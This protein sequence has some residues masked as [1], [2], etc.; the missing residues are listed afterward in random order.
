MYSDNSQTTHSNPTTL[1]R[2]HGRLLQD[3]G[4]SR[5]QR[6]EVF[7]VISN[8]VIENSQ[9]L[10]KMRS[11]G[12]CY[13]DTSS[14]TQSDTQSSSGSH[15]AEFIALVKRTKV[16]EVQP[17]VDFVQL[18]NTESEEEVNE[19]PKPTL[20]PLPE[21][22]TTEES[23]TYHSQSPAERERTEME[24]K[25]CTGGK[26][27]NRRF[28]RHKVK[29]LLSEYYETSQSYVTKKWMLPPGDTKTK[30]VHHAPV[31]YDR[32][33]KFG[34]VKK[35]GEIK[36]SHSKSK[37]N[38]AKD[39]KTCLNDKMINFALGESYVKNEIRA[40]HP[41]YFK[42][43]K[44]PLQLFEEKL[45]NKAAPKYEFAPKLAEEPA[46]FLLYPGM[47]S[48]IREWTGNLTS[49]EKLK[50][51]EAFQMEDIDKLNGRKSEIFSPLTELIYCR[52]NP[53]VAYATI[54]FENQ[55]NN[56]AEV[57]DYIIRNGLILP[58]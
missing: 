33:G 24:T 37:E 15:N 41:N 25:L 27:S 16:N 58:K 26:E 2:R 23:D 22:S 4:L 38:I 34:T 48:L 19:Q 9:T 32:T 17:K 43:T 12:K 44:T 40:L 14:D 1:K 10:Y 30:L 29:K 3:Y 45:K 46:S 8:L 51:R 55:P 47:I 36:S 39:I 42:P 56:Y 5:D 28:Y 20:T 18:T 6:K 50:I 53:T 49:L 54:I 21:S 13:T 35:R 52:E 31:E 11:T 57:S 7:K